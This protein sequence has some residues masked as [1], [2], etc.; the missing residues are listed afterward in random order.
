MPREL[1]QSPNLARS[2]TQLS[3]PSL[4]IRKRRNRAD[5]SPPPWCRLTPA[6][7]RQGL[8]STAY[9]HC[10]DLYCIEEL[11]VTDQNRRNAPAARRP[12]AFIT[13]VIM[14]VRSR[15][16]ALVQVMLHGPRMYP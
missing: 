7:A 5:L 13:I 8:G 11:E 14:T 10:I 15:A 16:A 1:F 12:Q 2:F 9:E 4:T 3:S 6:I